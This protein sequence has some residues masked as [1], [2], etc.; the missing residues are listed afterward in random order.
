MDWNEVLSEARRKLA[1][2]CAVCPVCNG[3]VCAGRMPGV[4]GLGTGAS[5]KNNISA[6][7]AVRLNMRTLH[8][9]A[10][11]STETTLFGQKLALPV[12]GA[13]VAGGKMNFGG[14]IAEED[15]AWAFV[16][17]A[18][19]AGTISMTGDGPAP[20]LLD[21]GLAAIEHAGGYGI[22]VLKPR[23]LADILERARRSADAGAA[24]IVVSNHGG[25]S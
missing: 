3:V 25:R 22:P 2:G 19:A 14:A 5:F 16:A 18:K 11:P 24:G 8:G 4:G 9:V 23:P 12:L 10:E 20:I 13:A 1:P 21:A 7:E 15:L 6:L 17:G